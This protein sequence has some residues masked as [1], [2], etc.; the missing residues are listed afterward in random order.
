MLISNICLRAMNMCG[1]QFSA[2][3]SP[4]G[5]CAHSTYRVVAAGSC[6]HLAVTEW[7]V[8]DCRR[9]TG[10]AEIFFSNQLIRQRD[11]TSVAI[12]ATL[13]D[14]GRSQHNARALFL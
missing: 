8:A 11:A 9:T 7:R 6:S 5:I 4:G 13:T 2:S 3:S 14:A 10:R 1:A 12:V